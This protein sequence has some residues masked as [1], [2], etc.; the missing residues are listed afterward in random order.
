[1]TAV[2]EP[3]PATNGDAT[4]SSADVL[5]PGAGALRGMP[6][7]DFGNAERLVEEHGGDIRY[8]K[9]WKTWLV[10]D[11]TRFAFDDTD[12]VNELAKRT[13]LELYNRAAEIPEEGERR[14]LLQHIKRSETAKAVQAMLALASSA[15]TIA[16]LPR[17]FDANPDLL[18]MLNGTYDSLADEFREHRREDLITK[19]MPVE[20][21]PDADCPLWLSF[22]DRIFAGKTETIAF[23]Q[24]ALGYSM[25]GSTV[26]HQLFLPIGFGRNGKSTLIETVLALAGDY[27][28]VAPSSLLLRKDRRANGPTPDLAELVGRRFVATSETGENQRLDEPL[29]KQATTQDTLNAC[30]KYGHPFNF[31]PTHKIWL[32]TNHAPRI[33]G[34]DEGVWS[35]IRRIPFNVRIPK[36]ERDKTLGDRL[37][38]EELPGINNWILDGL[39]MW[40]EHGLGTAEE[41]EAATAQYRQDED[42]LGQF[43]AD[44]CVQHPDVKVHT[45]ALYNEYLAW[46]NENG[47]NPPLS[48]IA[49]G[50]ALR[51]RGYESKTGERVDGKSARWYTGIGLRHDD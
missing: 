37:R 32:V 39:R 12:R 17:D 9:L 6:L 49:F 11:G 47:I 38:A 51:E 21:D 50:K 46:A 1:M 4:T 3:L 16:A 28:H 23:V 30:R 33:V 25:T 43:I 41:V 29:L 20:Y 7:T 5:G 10:W 34:T 31:R 18:N 42:V 27:G 8:C 24:R 44:R 36:H 40:R 2:N 48:G 13:I 22:L 35:R 19:L 45:T 26:E 15:P 14:K